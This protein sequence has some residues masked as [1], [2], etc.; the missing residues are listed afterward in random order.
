VKVTVIIVAKVITAVI[1]NFV[2]FL[3]YFDFKKIEN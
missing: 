2:D 3:K 1:T